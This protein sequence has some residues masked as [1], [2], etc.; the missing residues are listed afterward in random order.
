MNMHKDNFPMAYMK[1]CDC[2]IN[3]AMT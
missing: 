2:I 3:N 1:L